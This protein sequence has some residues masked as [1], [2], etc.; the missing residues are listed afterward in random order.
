MDWSS[1]G[2]GQPKRYD[3][4]MTEPA[5]PDPVERDQL[6][7]ATDLAMRMC[8]SPVGRISDELSQGLVVHAA[9][10]NHEFLQREFERL[11]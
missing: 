10:A 7:C 2:V 8:R 9:A 4:E 6:L 1:D 5:A 3:G 11:C